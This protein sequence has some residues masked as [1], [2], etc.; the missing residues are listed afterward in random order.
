MSCTET[1]KHVRVQT[2]TSFKLDFLLLSR[3]YCNCTGPGFALHSDI[4]V[5]YIAN[6]GSKEQIE[7]FIPD[8]TAGKSIAAIGMTEPG[9]GRS[10]STAEETLETTRGGFHDL[11]L[12]SV[13]S[14]V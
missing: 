14:R 10:G 2:S 5:P 3:M 6:Y 9:A 7:R 13:T 1:Q 12:S 4:V 11:S 8:M